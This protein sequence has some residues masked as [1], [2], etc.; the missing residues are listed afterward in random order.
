M[1]KGEAEG[2]RERL[3]GRERENEEET[4]RGRIGCIKRR[5]QV[6][7]WSIAGGDDKEDEPGR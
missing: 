5:E 3:H 7:D 4:G 6:T 2:T 1:E